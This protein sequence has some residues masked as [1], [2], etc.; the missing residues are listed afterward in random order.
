MHD[1]GQRGAAEPAGDDERSEPL[2]A[3]WKDEARAWAE[4]DAEQPI[5]L[6]GGDMI[7]AWEAEKVR[8]VAERDASRGQEGD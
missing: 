2:F 4:W 8:R 3:S 1:A 5:R 7:D 6:M